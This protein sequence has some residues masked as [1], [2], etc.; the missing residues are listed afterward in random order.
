MKMRPMSKRSRD[1][2]RIVEF[3]RT[4]VGADEDEVAE[5]LGI[6]II[7]VKDILLELEREGKTK[8]LDE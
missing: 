2:T 5:T 8:R 1:K 4:H 7:D 6:H 3:L